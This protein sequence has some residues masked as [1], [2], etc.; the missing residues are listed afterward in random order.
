M[1]QEQIA[2]L[3]VRLADHAAITRRA[4]LEPLFSVHPDTLR[5]LVASA[6]RLA[7]VTQERDEARRERDIFQRDRTALYDK[8]NGTPCAE[9]RWQQERDALRALI[10]RAVEAAEAISNRRYVDRG[11]VVESNAFAW[12]EKSNKELIEVYDAAR[13]LAADLRKAGEGA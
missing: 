1:T 8:L 6:E 4:P 13:A 10:A 12:F 5:D 2:Y 11:T 3:K 7:E 9:I